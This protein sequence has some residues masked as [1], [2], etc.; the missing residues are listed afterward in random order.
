MDDMQTEAMEQ[1]A[2]LVRRQI[3]QEEREERA[4]RN[5]DFVQVYRTN[6]ATFRQIIRENS[7]A[8]EIFY[9]LLEHMDH[10]NSLACSYTVLQEITGKSRSSVW[11]AVKYLQDQNY[12]S[13]SKMGNCNVYH[14]NAT[15]AWT[16]WG[17]S[18]RYA[19]FNAT[20]VV[21]ESEQDAPVGLETRRQATLGDN[22]EE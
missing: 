6:M 5:A 4:E 8:A 7:T 18:R 3:K 20:V 19:K 17:N 13:V 22:A 2:S 14:V 1:I 12:V 21:A 9:F 11:R 10:G 16:T 15:V